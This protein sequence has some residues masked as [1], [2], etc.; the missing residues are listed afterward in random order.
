MCTEY[1]T[2]PIVKKSDKNRKD[3]IFNQQSRRVCHQTRHAFD[4]CMHYNGAQAHI[5]TSYFTALLECQAKK[6][7]P[8]KEEVATM[9]HHGGDVCR[10][11]SL[12]VP[13]HEVD[14]QS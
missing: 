6:R 2:M 12:R 1:T 14:A 9:R 5:C 10:L 3:V 13:E 4:E 7:A 11:A 8:E